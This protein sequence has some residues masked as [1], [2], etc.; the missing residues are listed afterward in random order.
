MT[1]SKRTVA[2]GYGTTHRAIRKRWAALVAAGQATCCRCLLPI[3]P[4]ASWHLDHDDWDRTRYLGPSHAA[5]NTG[6]AS[7]KG[8][9][10][11]RARRANKV[12]RLKW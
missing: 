12:T 1:E 6:A 4:D 11:R 7:K 10:L 2:R 5:C 8:A 9:A 3:A